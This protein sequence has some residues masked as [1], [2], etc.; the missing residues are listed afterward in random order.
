VQRKVWEFKGELA[1]KV[2]MNCVYCAV[3]EQNDY[4][5]LSLIPRSLWFLVKLIDSVRKL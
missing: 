2:L 5:Q 3:V 4:A 1:I